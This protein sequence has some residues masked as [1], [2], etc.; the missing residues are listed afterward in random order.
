[1]D[2]HVRYSFSH[3]F[4][5]QRVIFANYAFHFER[6]RQITCQFRQYHSYKVEKVVFPS[7]IISQPVAITLIAY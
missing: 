2:N 1:M 3:G 6:T 7:A 4:V 5:L